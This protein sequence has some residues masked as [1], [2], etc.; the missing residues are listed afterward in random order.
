MRRVLTALPPALR[1]RLLIALPLTGSGL[2]ATG[3]L[4]PWFTQ[5]FTDRYLIAGQDGWL[6]V[7]LAGMAVTALARA[8]LTWAQ[9]QVLLGVQQA[10]ARELNAEAITA[11]L[12]ADPGALARLDAGAPGHLLRRL[13]RATVLLYSEVAQGLAE[14][15]AAPVLLIVMAWFDPLLAGVA[16]ALASLNAVAYAVAARRRSRLGD[17]LAQAGGQVAATVAQDLSLLPT[18]KVSAGET[19][20]ERRWRAAYDAQAAAAHRLALAGQVLAMAPH[21]ASG[22]SVAALLAT[23]AWRVIGGAISVGDLVACQTLLFSIN[24]ALQRFIEAS[25][26]YPDAAADLRRQ[27]ALLALPQVE[28]AM[29]PAPGA[30]VLPP[31]AGE[32]R[33][34]EV[35]FAGLP[36]RLTLPPGGQLAVAADEPGDVHAWCQALAGL[37]SGAAGSVCVD[38][39]ALAS[40]SPPVR[41]AAVALVDGGGAPLDDSLRENVRL[42]DRHLDDQAIRRALWLAG[43]EEALRLPGGLDRPLGRRELSGGQTRRVALAQALVRQPRVVVLEHA[44]EALDIALVRRILQRFAQTGLTA[45]V[46]SPRDEVLALCRYR[47]ATAGGVWTVQPQPLRSP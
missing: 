1:R 2:I 7:L 44:L 6:A 16:L 23:G 12:S 17:A 29:I 39:M 45:V 43:F 37:A 22:L 41:A 3:L 4:L 18:I 14:L 25:R 31:G 8:A 19:A 9:R 21:V 42:W 34:E 36:V 27:Q 11:F 46:V 5:V 24:D 20:V 32:L 10:A 33:V 15:P 38:G 30:A 13:H 35:P 28:P 40:L 47:L 26:L